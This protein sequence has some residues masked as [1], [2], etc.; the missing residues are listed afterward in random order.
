MRDMYVYVWHVH[1][2]DWV[3]LTALKQQIEM[4]LKININ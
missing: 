1:M 2:C 3:L 4:K